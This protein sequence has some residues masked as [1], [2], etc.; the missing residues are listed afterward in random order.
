MNFIQELGKSLGEGPYTDDQ[1]KQGLWDVLNSGRVSIYYKFLGV[2]FDKSMWEMQVVP[3]YG[4]AVLRKT[5]PRYT[6]QHEFAQ[7]WMADDPMIK[8]VAQIYKVRLFFFFFFP[9][10]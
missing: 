10:M 1:V 2:N 4:H 3:G 9:L 7:K 5:D 8:L 6:C